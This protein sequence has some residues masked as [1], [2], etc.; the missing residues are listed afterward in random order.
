M[1]KNPHWPTQ[2]FRPDPARNGWVILFFF[3]ALFVANTDAFAEDDDA[4]A[5]EPDEGPPVK[6]YNPYADEL[7]ILRE[8]YEKD[9]ERDRI[10]DESLA[11]LAKNRLPDP[12]FEA[13]TQFDNDWFILNSAGGDWGYTAGVRTGTLWPVRTGPD[14]MFGRWRQGSETPFRT[15][16]LTLLD[17]NELQATPWLGLTL[18]QEMYTPRDL[19]REDID[20]NDR[21]Y[22]GWLYVGGLFQLRGGVGR[23]D[24]ELDVGGTGRYSLAEPT[25]TFIHENTDAPDPHGWDHQI[26]DSLGVNLY[27]RGSRLLFNFQH[28]RTIGVPVQLADVQFYAE[29]AAGN[30]F[31]AQSIGSCVRLGWIKEDWVRKIEPGERIPD[32][33][34]PPRFEWDGVE[35]AQFY[36][37]SRIQ[38]QYVLYNARI[39]GLPFIEDEHSLSINPIV[40]GGEIGVFFRPMNAFSL[41]FSST[42]R[43]RETRNGISDS[44]GHSYGHVQL[45]VYWY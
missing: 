18:G 32:R 42:H 20:P 9:L 17:T 27:L 26:A 13:F 21:P 1:Q 22:A 29:T 44:A 43:T 35:M 19:D 24:V 34:I 38:S 45:M 41:I 37:Y 11:N 30:I 40:H 39:Q 14:S 7:R 12:D 25:Q 3:V 2:W 33:K 5:E 10:R 15:W 28:P 36:V 31:S 4:S 6:P 23:L 8:L 16:L